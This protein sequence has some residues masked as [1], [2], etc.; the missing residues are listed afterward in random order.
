MCLAHAA[1]HNVINPA[2]L[3]TSHANLLVV[4]FLT[5]RLLLST[6]GSPLVLDT[7]RRLDQTRQVQD[8]NSL[9]HNGNSMHYF[10]QHP[11]TV[12]FGGFI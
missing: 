11:N 3:D 5:G 4:A 7:Q 10:L 6:S 9:Y 12:Y 1:G 8:M 2:S